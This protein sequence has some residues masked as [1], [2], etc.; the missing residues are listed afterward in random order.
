ML[1]GRDAGAAILKGDAFIVAVMAAYM[2]NSFY[3]DASGRPFYAGEV[4]HGSADP[5]PLR[6]N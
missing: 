1:L 4:G 3:M 6:L 5:Q 2:V